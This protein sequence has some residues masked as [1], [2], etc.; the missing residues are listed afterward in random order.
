[1]Q[2]F[3]TEFK[4]IIIPLCIFFV[5]FVIDLITGIIKGKYIEGIQSEKLR[6]TIPKFCGYVG[7]LLMAY[8]L[9]C[10]ILT[11]TDINYSPISLISIIFFCITE[12]KSIV[13]NAQ[14]LGVKTPAFITDVI[15][16]L[17]EK[18]SKKG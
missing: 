2:I 14:I 6:A 11:S 5:F 4:K 3:I 18:F 15:N 9:D 13:E 8:F 17:S 1:M 10:L 7:M 12:V 16:T